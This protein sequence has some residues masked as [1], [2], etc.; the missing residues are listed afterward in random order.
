[1]EVTQSAGKFLYLLYF[2]AILMCKE[3]RRDRGSCQTC[4]LPQVGFFRTSSTF[5][6]YIILLQNKNKNYI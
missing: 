2:Y 1:M 5:F 4:F 6:C 3:R